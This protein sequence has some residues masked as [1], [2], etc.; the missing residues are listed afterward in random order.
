[1]SLLR[2]QLDTLTVGDGYPVAVVGIINRDPNTFFRGSYQRTLK[3]T[4]AFVAKMI[5]EGAD[6]VDVGGVSTAPGAAPISAKQE[7]RRTAPLI[8]EI[9]KHWAVPISIDTQN[10]KVASAAIKHGATIVNDVSGLKADAAMA[11]TITDS[12]ASCIVMAH[13]HQPGDCTTINEVQDA[14]AASLKI[15]ASAGI[16]KGN[17]VVDPGIGFGKPT[18][19]DLLILQNLTELRKLGHP[20]LVGVSRKAFIGYVLG[21]P[22]PSQRLAGSL[23]AVSFALL[24]GAH[25]IRAHDVRE[26]KDCIAIMEAIT[27][28]KDS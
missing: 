2:A 23:A 11:P 19:S 24:N 25:I 21:Y 26:N 27:K 17:I 4:L 3:R 20:I 1:L 9:S 22:S 14:L 12:G 13:H 7:Q 6:L 5:E 28:T 16:P 8:K 15:A 18:Y 10:S